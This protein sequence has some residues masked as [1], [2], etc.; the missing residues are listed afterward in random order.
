MADEAAWQDTWHGV[1]DVLGAKWTLHVLRAL[2]TGEYGFNELKRELDGITATMLS[3]RVQE[4][5]CHG[6]VER[7]VAETRPPTTTYRLTDHGAAVASH[8][9]ELEGLVDVTDCD[10]TADC[11][12]TDTDACV[13]A[14]AC[15]E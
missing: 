10:E 11:A 3:R 8:L 1:H 2:S 7:T 5:A 14:T 12:G 9:R 4:L 6:F 13:A 15:C